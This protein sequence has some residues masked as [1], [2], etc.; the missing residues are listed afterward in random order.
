[1]IKKEQPIGILDSGIGGF[2]VAK[3]VQKSLPNEDI[4]YFGD[5][6]NNPYGNHTQDEILAMT[7]YMLHFMRE[8]QVKTLLIACNTISCLIEQY[9]NEMP[10]PVLSVVQ[11]GADAV[12][13]MQ[14]TQVGVIST[15]FTHA[16]G[17]Y[18][19]LICAGAPEKTVRSQGCAELAKLVERYLGNPAGDALIDA[20]ISQNIDVLLAEGALDCLVL[21]CT[22]YPLVA[23]RIQKLYPTLTL[24]DPALQMVENT[25]AYLQA[26]NALQE[27]AHT[28]KLDIYTTASTQEYAQKAAQVGLVV[29][30]IQPY[31]RFV[32]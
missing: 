16:S 21:G 17:C 14:A 10:C 15:C 8:R 30:S 31:E 25:R 7:R 1:M 6:G 2:S 9:R 22:H 28:G 3:Q 5:G 19:Q 13:K 32:L 26:E 24:V 23:Q 12:K 18:Q 20:E 4:V 11:A 29:N 27:S